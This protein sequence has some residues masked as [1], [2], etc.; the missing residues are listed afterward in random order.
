MLSFLLHIFVL[1]FFCARLFLGCRPTK[2]SKNYIV[3]QWSI[4]RELWTVGDILLPCAWAYAKIVAIFSDCANLPQALA[5]LVEIPAI[6]IAM[7]IIM[8]TGKKWLFFT[9]FLSTGISC[10][11][12]AIFEG[13]G[14]MLWL[15]ITFVMIGEGIDEIHSCNFL[16]KASFDPKGKFTISAGNTIMPVYTAEL[17]PT[18][19]R[20]IGVGA[21]NMA[22][23]L[24]LVCNTRTSS[25]LNSHS[26]FIVL[27]R[28]SLQLYLNW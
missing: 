22:A 14:K 16:T 11:F 17:Y 26:I 4:K 27:C 12:A 2:I 21:C 20:N 8:K 24:A 7:Y 3:S 19:I 5:G 18:S 28:F 10:F 6:G 23:G 1:S 25:E 13:N 9:T 15:K